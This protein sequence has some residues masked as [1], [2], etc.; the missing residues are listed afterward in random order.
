MIKSFNLP[1]MVVGGEGAR[2]TARM[3]RH[4]AALPSLSEWWSDLRSGLWKKEQMA[5]TSCLYRNVTRR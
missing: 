1:G 3:T 5:G 4:S 2:A